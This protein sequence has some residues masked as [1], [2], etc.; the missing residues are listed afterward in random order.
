M[1]RHLHCPC[2]SGSRF[3]RFLLARSA[4]PLLIES[5]RARS[6][7]CR[8]ISAVCVDGGMLNAIAVEEP[9]TRNALSKLATSRRGR[10][11]VRTLA[12]RLRHER[13]GSSSRNRKMRG[14]G[15][16]FAGTKA[17]LGG[18]LETRERLSLPR[19]YPLGLISS[20]LDELAVHWWTRRL[21][22]RTSVAALSGRAAHGTFRQPTFTD[23]FSLHFFRVTIFPLFLQRGEG[24][25]GG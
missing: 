20:V 9:S 3:L 18:D 8:S 2:T 14:S 12:S 11:S 4:A 23:A 13:S 5:A 17:R 24:R 25:S 15:L 16:K 22:R 10:A 1:P 21:A 19:P 7:S 6:R